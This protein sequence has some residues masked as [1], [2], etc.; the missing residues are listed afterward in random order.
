[1]GSTT[2]SDEHG[3]AGRGAG[4]ADPRRRGGIPARRRRRARRRAGRRGGLRRRCPPSCGTRSSTSSCAARSRWPARPSSTCASSRQSLTRLR[5]GLAD[6]AEQAGARLRRGR[7]RAR[8]PG[9]HRPDRRQAPLPPD[10]ANASATSPPARASTACTC[11]SA[12]RTRRP[13]C[14]CSTTCA[15]GCR[16]C[17]PPPPTRRSS[18]GATPATRAG[19][20]S[21]WERWPTVG[22]TPY[23]ESHEQYESLLADLDRQRRDARRGDALLV[24]PA[25]GELPDR[26][27]P[28]GRRLPARSTTRCCWPRS[29][30]PWS[31]PSARRRA[32]AARAE[33]SPT[34]CWWPRTGGPPT[35]VWRASASTWRPGRPGRPGT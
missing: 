17:R 2:V 31:P 32:T 33:T 16:S 34:T 3:R 14:R 9:P 19:G 30:A 6:A 8:P 18:T 15:R 29:P 13:A 26:R 28:D 11:T 23:L 5:T 7:R 22:P 21:M 20:R 1:M 12:S 24:R 35:T 27:D 4:S 10:A 25:V